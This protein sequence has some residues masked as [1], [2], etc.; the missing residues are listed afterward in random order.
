MLCIENIINKIVLTIFE[1]KILKK[2]K[3]NQIYCES[4]ECVICTEF[5]TNE[6]VAKFECKHMFH[7]ECINEWLTINNTCPI[8]RHDFSIINIHLVIRLATHDEISNNKKYL[9]QIINK[10]FK[11][12]FAVVNRGAFLWRLYI[13]YYEIIHKSYEFEY[14]K[15]VFIFKDLIYTFTLYGMK[16]VNNKVECMFVCHDANTLIKVV[17]NNSNRVFER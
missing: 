4:Y 9:K 13:I 7:K 15:Y 10:F 3:N 17:L 1:N 11:K 12:E 14:E 16:L 2:Y 6:Y 5:I 8:C